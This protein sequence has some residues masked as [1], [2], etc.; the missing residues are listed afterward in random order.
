MSIFDVEKQLVF[1][2]A[3]HSNKTN[4]FIHKIFVPL[5]V[6]SFQVM[7]SSL[8]TPA[9]FPA[10]TVNYGE[11]LSFQFNWAAVMGIVY[12]AYYYTLV[13]S[14]AFLYTP[15][16]TL[17]VLNATAFAR[18]TEHVQLAAGLHAVAW[19]AQFLGHGLAEKRA[20]ALLD[21]LLGAVVLAP[22]FVHLEMLFDMGFYP[23][24]H[25]RVQNGVGKE[26]V[27]L[28]TA[29]AQKKRKEL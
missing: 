20:P 29:D 7:I 28:R 21:N 16:M 2:G 3:Y 10:Y 19:V 11:Y 17:S 13:P 23:T 26:L 5:I 1:Y 18:S 9:F 4:V 12:L 15:Q 27:R 8:P 22:F 24:L 6:W 25:K 14:A